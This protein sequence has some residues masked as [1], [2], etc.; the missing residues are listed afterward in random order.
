M[1]DWTE[2][3]RPS[4]LDE[5]RGNNNALRSL[6][7]WASGWGEEHTDAA[8]LHGP[9]GI[10]KT[11]A[12][13]ALAQDAGWDT[14]EMNASE[15]RTKDVADR[16]AG[17]ASANG[18]LTA[19]TAGRRLVILDEADNLH[20]NKDRGGAKAMGNIV[21][22]ANQPVVLIANDLYAMS[23]TL[24]GACENIEFEHVSD[25]TIRQL[26][27]D[28]CSDEGVDCGDDA[29]SAI[30]RQADGD[31]RAAVNDLQAA[32]SS[33]IGQAGGDAVTVTI[34][35]VPGSGR[36]REAELFPYIDTV[37]QSGTPKEARAEALSVDETPDDLV[38]WVEENVPKEYSVSE[39]MGA[40]SHLARADQWLGRVRATQEYSYWKYV[41]DHMSPGVANSRGKRG[42]SG[43]TPWSPPT[44]WRRLGQT[45]GKRVQR[46][47]IARR[48]AHTEY[49][50]VDTAR[51]VVLPYLEIVTHHCKNKEAT[52]AMARDY[53]FD[54][55]D[56]AF[57]TGSG[58]DTNKVADIVASANGNI[59]EE[60]DVEKKKIEEGG[61]DSN[62]TSDD[63][64]PTQT[65]LF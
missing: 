13:H 27:M 18:T 36:D 57:V 4:S 63:S 59:A 30:V 28:I 1:S 32:V 48:I 21:S 3:Y 42:H 16:V 19:G 61:D 51:D 39:M 58:E 10:G 29:V 22:E 64:E 20:G 12:A 60:S 34:D 50:S 44:T 35:D 15:T 9:P 54:E 11:T 17:S 56:V 49:M 23:K 55:S 47:D 53:E 25:R 5:V 43:F 65:T 38:Q 7:D 24:R 41:N 33:S 14:I 45:K 8:I 62:D 37:L 31:V 2:D 6:R 46:D 40:Y 26:L 52:I